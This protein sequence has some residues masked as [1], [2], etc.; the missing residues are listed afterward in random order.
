MLL[1]VFAALPLLAGAASW[2]S[3]WYDIGIFG[4]YPTQSYASFDLESPSVNVLQWDSRCDDGY[5]FFAP[6]GRLVA[7]PGPVILD[8][9]GNLVWIEKRFGQA[10]DVRVQRYKGQDYLTFWAGRDDKT[11]GYGVYYMVRSR[12]G[13]F[14]SMT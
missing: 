10:T 3:F 1:A 5:I 7:S 2:Y 13:V 8:S 4:L 9:R 14:R 6:R 11:H 12:P